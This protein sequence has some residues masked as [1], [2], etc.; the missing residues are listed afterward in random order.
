MQQ[1]EKQQSV[2]QK[3]LETF[4]KR[5]NPAAAPPPTVLQRVLQD[6][7]AS[8]KLQEA[9]AKGQQLVVLTPE[10]LQQAIEDRAALRGTPGRPRTSQPE[11]SLVAGLRRKK[12]N[13]QRQTLHRLNSRVEE[14]AGTKAVI[15]DELVKM[16]ESASS[17]AEFKRTAMQMFDKPWKS[18]QKIL[19]NRE[20]W[21]RRAAALQ[22]GKLAGRRKHGANQHQESCRQALLRELDSAGSGRGVEGDG[23]LHWRHLHQMQGRRWVPLL[24][25]MES[26]TLLVAERRIQCRSPLWSQW[27]SLVPEEQTAAASPACSL[28]DEGCRGTGIAVQTAVFK[29]SQGLKCWF[30]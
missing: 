2:K 24:Q 11:K 22:L 26:Y 4:F 27:C 3:T 28:S 17:P 16:S 7:Q 5:Q 13:L 18:L 20:E 19:K 30:F 12:N 1:E 6:R 10:E 29:L 23:G 25:P 21:H 9:R 14:S 15:A 8:S